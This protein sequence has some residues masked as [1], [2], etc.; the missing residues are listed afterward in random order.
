MKDPLTTAIRKIYKASHIR[1]VH[2]LQQERSKWKRRRTIAENKLAD[3]DR[4]LM[5]LLED[6]AH[7]LDERDAYE[8]QT[9]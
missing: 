3:N 7:K 5:A 6:W 1:Q 8:K 4:A 9:R 2:Q